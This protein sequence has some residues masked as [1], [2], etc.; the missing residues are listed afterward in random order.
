MPC[1][2]SEKQ[3]KPDSHRLNVLWLGRY[4]GRSLVLCNID[5][6]AIKV[7]CF[8]G[9]VGFSHRLIRLWRKSPKRVGVFH[10]IPRPEE[11]VEE[12]VLGVPIWAIFLKNR[13][14]SISSI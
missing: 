5:L 2:I 6:L 13:C 1:S 7:A 14:Y 9:S 8:M 4:G 12:V 11:R 10:F 3:E